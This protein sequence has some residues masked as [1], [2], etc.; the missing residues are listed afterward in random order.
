MENALAADPS[1]DWERRCAAI[2]AAG[3]DGIY[4]VPY[5]LS[6]DHWPRLRTLDEA[7][8][9]HG[10]RLAAVYANLDLAQ[11]D[12]APAARRLAQLFA[13]VDGAPR[14]ELSVKCSEPAMRF[15]SLDDAII[16][17]LAPLLALADRRK[18]VVALYPHS[19]YPLDTLAQASRI[20]QRLGSPRF[21]YLFPTSHV[22]ALNNAEETTATLRHHAGAIRSFNVCGC[23]R[24]AAGPP[25]HCVATPLDEGD[26]PLAPLFGALAAGGYSGD[27]IVQGHGWNG[28][29]PAQLR[30]SA[31]A[32]RGFIRA[33]FPS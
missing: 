26:L 33:C 32:A 20:L 25:A 13:E 23:R 24:L 22:Y 11:P 12:D 18:I 14:F 9:R 19:F 30:R 6:D 2:A 28:D 17:Q 1:L 27:V 29:L 21:G 8:A 4:A 15:T 7:P 16:R 5:P 10:L 31:V 3:F